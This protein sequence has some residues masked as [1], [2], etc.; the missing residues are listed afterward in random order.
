[1]DNTSWE[2]EPDWIIPFYLVDEFGPDCVAAPYE[3]PPDDPL[4]REH[5]ELS[6][7]AGGGGYLAA[8]DPMPWQPAQIPPDDRC[9]PQGLTLAVVTA[10]GRWLRWAQPLVDV[11]RLACGV[12]IADCPAL[13]EA[14]EVAMYADAECG[15][16]FAVAVAMI[17]AAG[18]GAQASPVTR[19]LAARHPAEDNPRRQRCREY[20]DR[21][22]DNGCGG[23]GE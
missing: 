21:L 8:H 22:R 12:W 15:S 2:S 16:L 7:M 10:D 11:S 19:Q 4:L 5:P 13:M 6:P 23:C 14:A 20:W 9:T 3:P 17:H 18:P 1:V